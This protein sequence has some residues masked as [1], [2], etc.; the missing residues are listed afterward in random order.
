MAIALYGVLFL[1]GTCFGSFLC[2]QARRLHYNASHRTKIIA[3]KRSVCLHCHH[4]LKWYDNIPII[5]WLVLKGKCRNCHRFI[6]IAEPISELGVGIAFLA[7]AT[8][9]DFSTTDP[10]IWIIFLITLVFTVVVGFLVI[11]DGLYGELPTQFLILSIIVALVILALQATTYL[12]SNPF[13]LSLIWRP[14][15]AIA[16]LGG[17]YLVL[18]LLSRGQWVGDGDWILATSLAIVLADPWLAFLNLFFANFLACL[19]M[20]P[21]VRQ[22][23]THKI[24]FGPFLAIA[25]IIAYV[26]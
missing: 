7:L 5:S 15:A 12:Q 25:F 3:S 21:F 8:T 6:G 16:I 24:Y 17:L 20:I 19:V 1:I 9:F 13:S 22:S 2:C 26:L 18:F 23:K 14:L 10:L 11:Y 4:Q